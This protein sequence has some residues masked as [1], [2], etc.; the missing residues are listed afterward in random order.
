M[1]VTLRN[2]GAV[3][4]VA[5]AA[6]I[7][8][9][10]PLAVG[11]TTPAVDDIMV[12]FL[13][14]END[15][16]VT[17][18]GATGWVEKAS[19]EESSTLETHIFWKRY[20]AAEPNPTFNWTGAARAAAVVVV[21]QGCVTSG[22]PFDVVATSTD[23]TADT[24]VDLPAITTTVADTCVVTVGS[25]DIAMSTMTFPTGL[26]PRVNTAANY[27]VVGETRRASAGSVG[28]WTLTAFGAVRDA[29]LTFALKPATVGGIALD[30]WVLAPNITSGSSSLAVSTVYTSDGPNRLLLVA[31]CIKDSTRTVASITY[32][33]Q[34]VLPAV[35]RD[36]LTAIRSELW[37]LVNPTA[38]SATVTVS[39]AGGNA[40]FTV[41]VIG[42]TGVDQT[43]P[44]SNTAAADNQTQTPGLVTVGSAVDEWAIDC[45]SLTPVASVQLGAG[46]ALRIAGQ[47]T[48]NPGS[49]NV[50]TRSSIKVSVG[51]S[52]SFTYTILIAQH[53]A[54]VAISMKPATGTIFPRTAGRTGTFAASP[55]RVAIL[56]RAP[57]RSGTFLA[58]AARQ[59]TFIRTAGRTG[60]VAAAAT[61]V[62]TLVRTAA[63]TGTF[64]A[65]VARQGTFIRTAIRSG[66]IA[67]NTVYVKTGGA[68]LVRAV[69]R[70]GTFLASVTRV[71]TFIR[72][73]GR[74]GTVAASVAKVGIYTRAAGRTGTFSGAVLKN[75]IWVRAVTRNGTVTAA[76]GYILIP[77][78]GVTFVQFGNIQRLIDSANYVSVSFYWEATLDTSNNTKPARAYI[79]NIT[80]SVIVPNSEI[81]TTA[82]TPTRVRTAVPVTLTGSK[83]YR[84]EFGGAP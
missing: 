83:V 60:T 35:T 5:S 80:D 43:T 51:A 72:T 73:A 31:V 74:T 37:Y 21:W 70:T 71:G 39:L 63:R 36:R 3:N 19:A 41:G 32:G 46:Q 16:A 18:S 66:G 10:I 78:G 29:C 75:V 45:M 52:V 11:G 15:T 59:G 28:G 81:T 23:S 84:I 33:S 12:A 68:V 25:W 53:W 50:L 27:L 38:G 4:L 7:T 40:K 17:V 1:A 24:T 65:A 54:T 55:A 79:Y 61:R 58:S 6:T 76:T 69:S 9:V 56:R 14:K 57:G 44:Y 62:K 20:I 42:F 77:A 48:G 22:D 64:L 13:T 49:S 8:P 82:T 30:R 26:Q 34:T 2:V 67:A 47:T